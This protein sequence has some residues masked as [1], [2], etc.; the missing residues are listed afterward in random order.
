MN[1]LDPIKDNECL[2]RLAYGGIYE[3]S[4]LNRQ[5]IVPLIWII[6]TLTIGILGID[7]HGS[8]DRIE[9]DWERMASHAFFPKSI[10]KQSDILFGIG[11]LTSLVIMVN[12]LLSPRLN[13]QCCMQFTWNGINRKPILI[14]SRG[15][16]IS[17]NVSE[18]IYKQRDKIR[19]ITIWLHWIWLIS[20]C[21]TFLQ[22]ILIKNNIIWYP[23]VIFYWIV[24]APIF[25]NYI[26]Y[27]K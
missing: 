15:K 24:M 6:C 11:S 18:R 25:F 4:R 26:N 8:W 19:K 22:Q 13:R 12:L 7:G 20:T 5:F 14:D 9:F 2:T 23:H 21:V 27:S 10:W 16:R 1:D 17:T 3:N